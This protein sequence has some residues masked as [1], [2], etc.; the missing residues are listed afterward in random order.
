MDLELDNIEE[1]EH[2]SCTAVGRQ[3]V[4]ICVPIEVHPF[5]KVGKITVKCCE[6]PV[7]EED[8]EICEE[9]CN[10]IIKQKIC[11]EVPIEFGAETETGDTF[12]DC[13]KA[14]SEHDCDE[15]CEEDDEE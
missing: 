2:E 10:F 1:T 8:E 12:I 5:A 7:V 3:T 15:L 4:D 14:S 9:K 13:G 6:E 11:I